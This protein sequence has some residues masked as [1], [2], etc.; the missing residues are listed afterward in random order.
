MTSSSSARARSNVMRASSG[1]GILA[2]AGSVPRR[3]WPVHDQP[4]PLH[5]LVHLLVPRADARIPLAAS[6]DAVDDAPDARGV[7]RFV[8]LGA[9]EAA[10]G[11]AVGFLVAEV[12]FAGQQQGHLDVG[13]LDAAGDLPLV[14]G[15]AP[16][17]HLPHLHRSD[18]LGDSLEHLA[19]PRV[20]I[21]DLLATIEALFRL[22]A[23]A[24]NDLPELVPVRIRPVPLTLLL[25]I[26]EIGIRWGDADVPQL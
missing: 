7:L 6:I 13:R 4:A 25:V 23:V 14:V 19:D 9:A 5:L 12:G 16:L 22:G 10:H 26:G 17:Q 21:P 3:S 1:M 20:V 2:V 8:D 24:P 18:R 11:V 15:A